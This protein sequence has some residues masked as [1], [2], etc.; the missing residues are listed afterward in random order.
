MDSH[1]TY[2]QLL[3]Q[4]YQDNANQ[5]A[6]E[7]DDDVEEFAVDAHAPTLHTEIDEQHAFRQFPGN[8]NSEVDVVKSHQFE[9]KSKL[10]VRYNKDVRTSVFN[11]D[12][13]FRAYA[14]PSVIQTTYLS[15]Y[16]PESYILSTATQGPGHF[17]FRLNRQVKNAISI[18]LT[19]LELPNAFSNFSASRSNACFGVRVSGSTYF[20]KVDI[21][22]YVN[23][24]DTPRY[25]PSPYILAAAVQTALR[26]C[27]VSGQA[28]FTCIVNSGGYIQI[29]NTSSPTV[30]YDFDFVTNVTT[31]N[32]FGSSSS[33]IPKTP[34]LFDTL[35][36]VLG[37]SQNYYG[38]ASAPA[39]VDETSAASLVGI[40]GS[41][42]DPCVAP[43]GLVGTYFP[44]LNTDEYIY[45]AINEYSTVIPQTT[46]G[47][48]FPVFAKIPVS[49][50][51]GRTIFDTDSSNSTR[52][53]FQFLQPTNLQTLE[54]RLLDRRGIVLSNVRDYS[55]TLEIEEVVSQAL[56]EKLREL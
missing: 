36:D 48:Y 30:L 52:K 43:G 24:V 1:V 11:I 23:G 54:I 14:D 13:R 26:N 4:Q 25:F 53:I 42:A 35:G 40:S 55:M 20:Q 29:A 3:A 45:L 28:N 31:Q 41:C 38:V 27:G 33:T 37:F 19:S 21:A 51:K 16:K 7:H 5:Y 49:V 12:P 17:M 15:D 32:L 44:D 8:R 2:H 10:S 9:D 6:S 34:Q 50:D 39:T 22:P 47:S 46:D 56:Y 18:R